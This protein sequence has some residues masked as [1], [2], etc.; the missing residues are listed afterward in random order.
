MKRAG[1]LIGILLLAVTNADAFPPG[2]RTQIPKDQQAIV[3]QYSLLEPITKEDRILILAPHPDDEVIGCSG[4]I[5]KAVA[6]GASVRIAYLTNG[7]AN[8]LAF[9]VYEKR[10]TFLPG[11]FVHMGEVRRKEATAAAQILGLNAD[12]L[13]FFGYPDFGT[14]TMFQYYWGSKKPYRSLLSRQTKVPYKDNYSFDKSYI[15]ENVLA[16]ITS[17]LLD[18]QPTR[19]FVTHPA[20]SNADHRAYCLYFQIA[21]AQVENQIPKPKV[22][23]YLVHCV[24]WPLPRHYHPDYPLIPPHQLLDSEIV[25]QR[26]PLTAAEIEKKHKAVLCNRSQ[27]SSSAFYLLSFVR[28]NE[29][30]GSYPDVVLTP[31]RAPAVPAIKPQSFWDRTLAFFGISGLITE[32]KM[33]MTV[34]S[35][36][37]LAE[38]K[39]NVSYAV[40]DS[41]LLIRIHKDE[42]LNR[43]M[44]A[45]IY[46]YGFSDRVDF[47]QMPK[48]TVIARH[49]KC[50]VLNK[51]SRIQADG[52]GVEL[53]PN[54]MLVKVPL[55]LLG[56]PTI[57]VSSV[58][59]FSGINSVDM[60]A[61]R[62]IIIEEADSHG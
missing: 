7:D 51:R 4:V 50:R 18:F 38:V 59:T 53:K 5:Q 45:M 56:N 11:E 32:P 40:A 16:D 26:L 9:I 28:S 35:F 22:Y 43:R 48:I 49:N 34:G 54:E 13:T 52:V 6:A 14:F 24:G 20:D 17:V 62:T 1:F 29:L 39:G 25:W 12:N 23:N 27:T 57:I 19:V 10:L 44:N 58:K 42:E 46:L 8:Q 33:G 47:A 55:P 41:C 31:P 15:P 30:F 60:S 2:H 21:L 37:K 61:F 36:K 3:Q